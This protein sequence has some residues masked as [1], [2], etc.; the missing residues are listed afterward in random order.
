[1]YSIEINFKLKQNSKKE[2]VVDG[3]YSYLSACRMNGQ[4]LDSSW[5]IILKDDVYTATVFI[6]EKTSLSERNGNKY[7][8]ESQKKILLIGL[9][10]PILKI[11][12]KEID[13]LPVGNFSES[14]F[15]IVFTN[16]LTLESCIRSGDTFKP[17]PFYKL[18]K[19]NEDE[20]FDLICWQ[21]DYKSCDSLQMGCQ[22]GDRFGTKEI[23]NVNSSLTKR[24][25]KICKQLSE[26]VKK[27]FYYYLYKNHGRSIKSENLRDCPICGNKH[28]KLE[29]SLHG[30]FDFKCEN[31][32]LL[33][34]IAWDFR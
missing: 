29:N 25:F 7:V 30:L 23:S 16:Y 15:F 26:N 13:S 33:S 5:S 20:Y 19:T 6:P 12:G 4:I 11:K 3:I 21:S 10:K 24:G 22:T 34:N 32:N 27:P 28:W 17:I 14:K 18:P 1:M 8:K 2:D 31:C 9:D